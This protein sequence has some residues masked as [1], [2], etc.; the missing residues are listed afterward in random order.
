MNKIFLILPL[1]ALFGCKKEKTEEIIFPIGMF[2][3]KAEVVSDTK[4]Y[5]KGGQLNDPQKVTELMW[6]YTREFR[7]EQ[8]LT[9]AGER[10]LNFVAKDSVTFFNMHSPYLIERNGNRLM[11]TSTIQ[12]IAPLPFLPD[13]LYHHVT[14]HQNIR[15]EGNSQISMDVR[16]AY[17]NNY[18]ELKLP[19]FAYVVSSRI[20]T[21]VNRLDRRGGLVVNE[22]N[23]DILNKLG[24]NDTILVKT[25]M[26]KVKAKK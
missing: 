23:E 22:F 18:D 12:S 4:I 3:E 1:I 13:Q 5:I 8:N 15:T 11:M 2:A 25:Y 21:P 6:I 10:Y 24:K 14:K 17:G 7:Q 20:E 9:G 19:M 16:V 26:L